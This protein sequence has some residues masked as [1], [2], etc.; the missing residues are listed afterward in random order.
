MSEY[1]SA[2]LVTNE[3]LIQIDIDVGMRSTTEDT[4]SKILKSTPEIVGAW[5]END[6]VLLGTTQSLSSLY[7]NENEYLNGFNHDGH[8]KGGILVIKTD[9]AGNPINIE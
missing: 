7:D 3:V 5:P 2:Y 4:P 1:I 9:E 8:L 6:Y